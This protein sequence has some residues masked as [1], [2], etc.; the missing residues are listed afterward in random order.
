MSGN[1]SKCSSGLQN[2]RSLFIVQMNYTVRKWQLTSRSSMTINRNLKLDTSTFADD[3]FILASS[4]DEL[5]CQYTTY[6]T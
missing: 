5:Q 4:G 3:Q 2:F 1:K 6:K